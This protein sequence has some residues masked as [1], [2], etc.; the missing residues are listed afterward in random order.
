[1]QKRLDELA[2]SSA[3]SRKTVSERLKFQAELKLCRDK[4]ESSPTINHFMKGELFRAD[5][6]L[7]YLSSVRNRR[8]QARLTSNSHSPWS[9][10]DCRKP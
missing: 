5:T 8:S 6:S 10:I 2:D 1:M 4:I 7:E 3:L 9:R